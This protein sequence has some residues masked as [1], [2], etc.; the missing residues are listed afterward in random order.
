MTGGND[1]IDLKSV[2]WLKLPEN[3]DEGILQKVHGVL[4]GM[5]DNGKDVIMIPVSKGYMSKEDVA[6]G[7]LRAVRVNPT[8][9]AS[10]AD[11]KKRRR[12]RKKL[13]LRIRRI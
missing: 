8:Y 9:Y 5:R 10:S 2:Y 7:F 11:S 3:E 1:E 6:N 13:R 4:T 12:R